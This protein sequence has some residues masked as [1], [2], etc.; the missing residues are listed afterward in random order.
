MPQLSAVASS[1]RLSLRATG[2]FD[3]PIVGFFRL[4]A[5]SGALGVL[6]GIL[7]REIFSPLKP[8]VELRTSCVSDGV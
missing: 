6:L 4:G 5:S 8:V 1:S 2:C 7:C 3:G